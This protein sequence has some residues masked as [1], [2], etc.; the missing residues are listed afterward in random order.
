MNIWDA[1]K[2]NHGLEHG[3]IALI[4]SRL[5]HQQPMAGYS[6]P[7]GFFVVGDVTTDQ[8]ESCSAEA[9][10]R[11]QAGEADLAVSPFC[12]T[13]IVVGAALT[14]LATIAGYNAA[15]RGLRGINRAFSNAALAIVASQP[16]GRMVQRRYTTSADV[17]DMRIKGVTRHQ[18]G[19]ITVHWV[20]TAFS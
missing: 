17:G 11:M 2:R 12:G 16:L 5:P 18:M 14:T 10:S 3:T 8:V 13:N 6:I 7:M 1:T 15:G 20:A 19:K 9:L 4:M